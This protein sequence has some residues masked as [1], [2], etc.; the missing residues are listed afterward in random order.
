MEKWQEVIKRSRKYLE[1]QIEQEEL[2][3]KEADL[4]LQIFYRESIVK[5]CEDE[6]YQKIFSMYMLN[7]AKILANNKEKLEKDLETNKAELTK[8]KSSIKNIRLE[9]QRLYNYIYGFIYGV[10]TIEDEKKCKE[11][12][13]PI[14]FINKRNM[15][16]LKFIVETAYSR[17]ELENWLSVK[18]NVIED[19]HEKV[20]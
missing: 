2:K 11:A 18:D 3:Q 16:Y 8:I 12:Y 17:D 5:L 4:K 7:D 1:L 20:S 10:L 19:L 6:E 14:S 15:T 9:S 13:C